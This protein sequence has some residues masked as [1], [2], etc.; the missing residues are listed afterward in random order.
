MKGA[1]CTYL[2]T[3]PTAKAAW[4]SAR[5]DVTGSRDLGGAMR[6]EA[7][8]EGTAR[9]KMRA[10]TGLFWLLG[11]GGLRNRRRRKCKWE[12]LGGEGTSRF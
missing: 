6:R 12:E 11:G 1:S 7:W 5:L 9:S 2:G 3:T 4:S 10:I 8:I